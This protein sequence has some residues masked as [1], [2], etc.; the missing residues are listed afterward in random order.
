MERWKE[1]REGGKTCVPVILPLKCKFT[2]HSPPS[3]KLDN[4]N[5]S[6]LANML[7]FVSS[8]FWKVQRTWLLFLIS[9]LSFFLFPWHVG[10]T[11]IHPCV[12]SFQESS[13]AALP[14]SLWF[15]ASL[16]ANFPPPNSA[17]DPTGIPAYYQ[18]VQQHWQLPPAAL[19][20]A[21]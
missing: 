9:R 18:R 13:A 14:A 7:S 15:L 10:H 17:G 3:E 8:W 12:G 11:D 6:L 16:K 1:R 2:L 21:S 5:T 20:Q 4:I 19:Q